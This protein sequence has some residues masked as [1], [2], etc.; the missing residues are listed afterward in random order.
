M[1]VSNPHVERAGLRFDNRTREDHGVPL[2]VSN[3]MDDVGFCFA[4]C[5]VD[6][7]NAMEHGR[8][9]FFRGMASFAKVRWDLIENQIVHCLAIVLALAPLRVRK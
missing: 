7:I 5:T 9:R 2:G 4:G 6:P 1:F 3:S 8:L